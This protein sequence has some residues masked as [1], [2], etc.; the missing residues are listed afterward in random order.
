MKNIAILL[1]VLVLALQP[2]ATRAQEDFEPEEM[3]TFIL[4]APHGVEGSGLTVGGS[5]LSAY[6]FFESYYNGNMNVTLKLD[7]PEGFVL[8]ETPVHSFSL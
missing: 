2:A 1:L 4:Q 8:L 3:T 5:N 7:L 6:V